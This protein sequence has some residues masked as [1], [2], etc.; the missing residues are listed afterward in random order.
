MHLFFIPRFLRGITFDFQDLLSLTMISMTIIQVV[1]IK[2][3][4]WSSLV[5][6]LGKIINQDINKKVDQLSNQMNE[7]R[8]Q[9]EKI[10]YQISKDR[11]ITSRV[12]I[13]RFGDEVS[14]GLKHS[15]E[16]FEQVLSDIDQYEKYCRSHPEFE[17]NK[18]VVTT[19]L[20]KDTYEKR[21]KNHDF[22]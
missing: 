22:I 15:E 10:N 12:R 3:N 7:I 2:I 17:N 14:R 11:A 8:Y 19:K 6:W 1:P 13:L 20:I 4:P 16:N 5:K 21:L 9:N 18:T